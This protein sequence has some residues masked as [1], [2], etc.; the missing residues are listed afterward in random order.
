MGKHEEAGGIR[1]VGPETRDCWWDPRPETWDP[2]HRWDSR[3]E[4]RDAKGRLGTQ[5]VDFQ[6]TFC[7][8]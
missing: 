7:Y 3:P 4:T 2:C 8:L 1:K 6:S 5:R